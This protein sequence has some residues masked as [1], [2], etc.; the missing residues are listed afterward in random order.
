MC[1]EMMLRSDIARLLGLD[2]RTVG[3]YIERADIEG[4]PEGTQ[5]PKYD[6]YEVAGLFGYSR[7]DVQQMLKEA[8]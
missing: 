8:Q 1:K 5:R 6:L 2:R 3:K 4:Y 7:D